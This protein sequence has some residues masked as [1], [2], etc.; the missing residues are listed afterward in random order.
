MDTLLDAGL[1]RVKQLGGGRTYSRRDNLCREYMLAA[2]TR[3]AFEDACLDG[4]TGR[5]VNGW[6]GK[7]TRKTPKHDKKGAADKVKEAWKVVRPCTFDVEAAKQHL[8]ELRTRR[9][10]AV[11]A[12][13]AAANS[14]SNMGR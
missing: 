1:I 7:R 8:Q 4:I 13:K 3:D 10:A 11:E 2:S 14:A 12:W 9:E 6:T 5:W